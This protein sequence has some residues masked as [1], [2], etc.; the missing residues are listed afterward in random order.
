MLR[1]FLTRRP[2]LLW[3]G[4]TARRETPNL[5]RLAGMSDAESFVWAILPHAARSFAASIVALPRPKARAAAVAYLY[6]RMLDTYED[7]SPGAGERVEKLLRFGWRLREPSL[8]LPQPIADTLAKDDRDRLHLLLVARCDLVDEMYQ[9]LPAGQREAIAR[10]VEN[11]AEGMAWSTRT[12]GRQNG[13]LIGHEQVVRYCHNVIG[14]PALFALE[15][16]DGRAP[17]GDPAEDALRVSEMV[18]LA[19][20]TRDIEKDL[21]RG[22]AY[23]AALE[24]F[25][26]NRGDLDERAETVRRVREEFLELALSRVPSYVRLFEDPGVRRSPAARA[27]A[28]MMLS[29]TDMHYRRCMEQAGHKAW[30]GPRGPF[31]T[32][33]AAS[34]ALVSTGA[35]RRAIRRIEHR[36]LEAATDLGRPRVQK[37]GRAHRG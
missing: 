27:A 9:A 29:F 33:I 24:P 10:L 17:E 18:Q 25:T 22:V 26:H 28:V 15:V 36:F 21:D 20:I 6:C 32:V 7:L 14:H 34:P 8:P 23:H 16:L 11:M 4:L 19:N 30:R 2:V 5:V 37:G 31:T 13:V 1:W 35:A 3:R 12:L